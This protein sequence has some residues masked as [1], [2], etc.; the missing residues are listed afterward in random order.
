MYDTPGLIL[1]ASSNKYD[2]LLELIINRGTEASSI[3]GDNYNTSDGS[4]LRDYIDVVDLARAHAVAISRLIE[5]RNKQN[6]RVFNVG[7]VVPC[8]CSILCEASRRLTNLKP[9]YK[10]ALRRAGDVR[11]CGC[12][13]SVVLEQV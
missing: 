10:V 12:A 7:T 13:H 6:Y 5:E 2:T 3:F 9:N 8:R 4:C 1:E 11:R